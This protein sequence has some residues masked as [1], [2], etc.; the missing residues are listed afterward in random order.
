MFTK[1]ILATNIEK[2]KITGLKTQIPLTYRKMLSVY[3]KLISNNKNNNLLGRYIISI[4]LCRFIILNKFKCN[5]IYY[6]NTIVW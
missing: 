5:L 2:I 6:Q 3:N 4:Y 1:I